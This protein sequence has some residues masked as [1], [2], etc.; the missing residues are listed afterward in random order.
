[1]ATKLLYVE[2]SCEKLALL[3]EMTFLKND[4]NSSSTLSIINS[5]SKLGAALENFPAP[6]QKKFGFTYAIKIE[7]KKRHE[8]QFRAI[9]KISDFHF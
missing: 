6:K 3:E 4:G 1:M 7:A 8:A 9:P 5:S 2:D